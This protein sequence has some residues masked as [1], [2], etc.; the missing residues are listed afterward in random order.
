MWSCL[1]NVLERISAKATCSQPLTMPIATTNG[2]Y[3]DDFKGQK[4]DGK[5]KRFYLV[6]WKFSFKKL[7]L[8]S[9]MKFSSIL[10]MSGEWI[11][12]VLINHPNCLITFQ[13]IIVI[14]M[15][16]L[17]VA[18]FEAQWQNFFVMEKSVVCSWEIQ[19]CIFLTITTYIGGQHSWKLLEPPGK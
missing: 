17:H 16:L 2:Y 13:L 4:R 10:M 15:A 6:Y 14:I 19:S 3:L 8:C 12:L 7:N 9:T 18:F 1:F 11:Y 5:R